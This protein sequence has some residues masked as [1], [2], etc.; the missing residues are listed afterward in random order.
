ML[1]RRLAVRVLFALFFSFFER[2]K[3]LKCPM[4]YSSCVQLRKEKYL[5]RVGSVTKSNFFLLG[6]L[7]IVEVRK[8]GIRLFPVNKEKMKC[9]AFLVVTYSDEKI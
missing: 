1:H 3:A 9:S 6:R 2:C 7:S 4:L 8:Y 5:H